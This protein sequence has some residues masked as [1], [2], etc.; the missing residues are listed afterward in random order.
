MERVRF[1]SECTLLKYCKSQKNIDE[2]T[3]N[4]SLYPGDGAKNAIEYIRN[5]KTPMDCPVVNVRAP[6]PLPENLNLEPAF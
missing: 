5:W 2:V 6:T 4:A 3:K 1:C